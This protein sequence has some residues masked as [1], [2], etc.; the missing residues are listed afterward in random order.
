[1]TEAKPTRPAGR[2]HHGQHDGP[3]SG[4]QAE[5]ARNDQRILESA[6]AVFVA[7]PGAPITAVAK[8]AGVGISALY[9]RY[10][11]KEELL[12]TL[13][14]DGLVI[15]IDET[16]A[17]IERVKQGQ[18]RWA[19]F[20]DFMHR[21]ADAD[22]SSMTRALA[23]KFVPTPEMFTLANRSNQLMETFFGLIRDTLRPGVVAHDVSLVF[24][25]VAALK[26][27]SPERT[28][29]LRHRYLTVILDGLRAG[30]HASNDDD[31]PGP[32]PA[33]TELTERWI[34]AG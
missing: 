2:Q 12:R 5:A 13:C 15:V 3:L 20:T 23:G 8:H 33:W 18:D 10:G 11:S 31:L 27:A 6:R 28:A 32:P 14:T 29:E 1:M 24:E 34:P 7:D 30:S 4:R 16:E 22:T 9:T 17:A 19:V 25:L 21:L 26:F